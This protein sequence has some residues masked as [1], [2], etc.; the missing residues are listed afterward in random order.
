MSFSL[1]VNFNR[2]TRGGRRPYVRRTIPPKRPNVGNKMVVIS[3]YSSVN[4]Q[5]E[6]KCDDKEVKPVVG[7]V[8]ENI[9]PDSLLDM[10][11][12]F[13]DENDEENVI[14]DVSLTAYQLN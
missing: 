10:P 4:S 8:I 12:V 14:N 11:V 3:S 13:A 5:T 1:L 2:K 9:T 6:I 7:A